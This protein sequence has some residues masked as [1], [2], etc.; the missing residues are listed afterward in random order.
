MNADDFIFD[1]NR[2]RMHAI[3]KLDIE[4]AVS[5]VSGVTTC[6]STFSSEKP[7]NRCCSLCGG[8]TQPVQQRVPLLVC[9][10]F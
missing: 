3:A 5:F 2:S 10:M 1:P 6:V 9:C 8:T 4:R 7:E